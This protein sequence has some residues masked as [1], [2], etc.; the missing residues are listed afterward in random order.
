[1]FR[2]L[3][4]RFKK[5][6][7]Q[8]SLK[9]TRA[10][11]V[12]SHSQKPLSINVVKDHIDIALATQKDCGSILYNIG[13]TACVTGS[14]CLFE[15]FDERRVSCNHYIIVCFLTGFLEERGQTHSISVLYEVVSE[16]MVPVM[17]SN[18]AIHS[19][20]I[21]LIRQFCDV[22]YDRLSF[23]NNASVEQRRHFMPLILQ[24]I[25]EYNLDSSKC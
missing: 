24:L 18:E 5:K 11:G 25:L 2:F 19:D 8:V 9:P 22:L 16:Y 20:M 10:D 12:Q 14:R 17:R 23:H 7:L 6:E 21:E 3:K 1:M 4:D 15:I 13:K